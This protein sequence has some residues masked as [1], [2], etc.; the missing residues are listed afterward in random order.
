MNNREFLWLVVAN[1]CQMSS[2]INI[3]HHCYQEWLKYQTFTAFQVKFHVFG[4]NY[5]F[6]FDWQW[7]VSFP[8]KWH[9]NSLFLMP[10][11]QCIVV[12]WRHISS[13]SAVNIWQQ[14][15]SSPL[16][17]WSISIK[18]DAQHKPPADDS[19]DQISCRWFYRINPLQMTPQ[20]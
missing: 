4:F 20:N 14:N 19:I 8:A 6:P 12:Q 15:V 13:E 7:L 5:L 18:Y 2:D 3:L 10:V 17:M 11:I 1:K 9:I 16:H